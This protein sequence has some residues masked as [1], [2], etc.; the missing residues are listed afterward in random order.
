GISF[1]FS[2]ALELPSQINFGKLRVAYASV[3][4]DTDPYL[5]NLTYGLQSYSYNG[6]SL[7]KINQENVPNENLR[8]LSVSE[9]EVGLDMKMF[10]NRLGL[11]MAW[12]HKL[13]TNDIAIETISS[14]SGYQGMSVNVG[15]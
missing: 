15:E 13:T 1:V 5:L 10:N 3:G 9:F 8:P 12:Y 6:K 7:G 14:T 4:G 2:E 11:D